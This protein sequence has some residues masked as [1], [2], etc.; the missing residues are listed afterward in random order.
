MLFAY[1]SQKYY[2]SSSPSI[3][4]EPEIYSKEN[5]DT[6]REILLDILFLNIFSNNRYY[7]SDYKSRIDQDNYGS[8]EYGI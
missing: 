3:I 7:D 2:L 5:Y 4:R 8:F 6:L 1:W